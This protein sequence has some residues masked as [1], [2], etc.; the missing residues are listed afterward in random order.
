[1]PVFTTNELLK[2]LHE[3]VQAV[4]NVLHKQLLPQPH[5]ALLQQPAPGSW[6]AIQCLDHLN[7]Y[8]QFYIPRLRAALEKGAAQGVAAKPTFKS[9]WL[10]N[11]FTNLMVPKEDGSLRMKMQAPKGYRPVQQPDA[12]KTLQEFGRQQ[13]QFLH[14]L[15]QASSTDIARV[16]VPTTLSSLLKLSA[17]DTFRFL[18]AHEQRHVLQAL[19]AVLVAGGQNNA[20]VSMHYFSDAK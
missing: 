4:R 11:Y 3:D 20:M 13:D 9:S 17:G 12:E 1:M 5:A 2:G 14:L 10:G 18:I 7:G 6:S 8:G 19:R 16:K 15:Q